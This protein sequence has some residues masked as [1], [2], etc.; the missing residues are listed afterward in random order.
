MTKI[1]GDVTLL[2]RSQNYAQPRSL[3]ARPAFHTLVMW[4][5]LSPSNCI[6]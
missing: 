4:V 3:S 1:R 2:R 5:I 6:M